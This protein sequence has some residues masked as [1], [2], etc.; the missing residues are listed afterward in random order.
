[1]KRP[2]SGSRVALV[3]G[4]FAVSFTAAQASV[5]LTSLNY[6]ENFDSLPTTSVSGAFS[7]TA[8]VQAAVPGTT[9]WDGVKV[10]GTGSTNM[11]FSADNGSA[12][13]GALYSYGAT[14]V[15]ERALGSIASGSNVPAFGVEIVNNTGNSLASVSISYVG[16]FWRSSTSTQ[17]VLSF[18]YG[19]SGGAA[20]S[21][22]YLTAASDMNA[23]AGLNLVGPAPVATNGLLDG[24]AAANQASVAAT[25]TFA[26]PLAPGQ[27]LFLRWQDFNDL[28]NDAA[29]AVD[30]FSLTAT[31]TPEPATLSLLVL[32]VVGMFMRRQR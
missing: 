28:G 2:L 27:S 19:V 32:S 18:G 12:N 10:S 20:S 3:A 7:L 26:A 15:T 4:L 11:N 23:V 13:A 24:N 6:A 16:E 25:I 9:G 14:G 17:N 31:A 30:N 29:L 8:G 21:S 1:M 5:S 22:N